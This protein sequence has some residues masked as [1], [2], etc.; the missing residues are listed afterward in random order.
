MTKISAEDTIFRSNKLINCRGRLVDLQNPLIMGIINLTP[1]SFF[2]G[3]K[4]QDDAVIVERAKKLIENGSDILDLGGQSTRPGATLLDAEEEWKRLEP[5]LKLIRK[6]FPD[7]LLSVD[8]FHSSVAE[9]AFEKGVSIIN[10]ISGGEMDPKMFETIAR[11]NVPYVLMHIQGTPKTMQKNPNYQNVVVE[12]MDYFSKKVR[13]LRDMGVKDIIIDPGFGFGKTNDHNYLL[14]KHLRFF[15][16]LNCP[17]LVGVSRKSMVT[18]ELKNIPAMA[19]NGTTVLNTI[20]L[21]NGVSILR[22]HDPAEAAEVRTLV[23]RYMQSG[24]AEIESAT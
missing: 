5:A 12:V 7:T 23:M 13:T 8:T 14:L 15:Q 2:D 3:G 19:L 18:K 9:R 6:H 21:M 11:L 1:D 24:S 10:D 17:L 22:V 4:L 16:I 20:A